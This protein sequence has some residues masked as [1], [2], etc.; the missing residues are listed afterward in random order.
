MLVVQDAW[1]AKLRVA[2]VGIAGRTVARGPDGSLSVDIPEGQHAFALLES[3]DGRLRSSVVDCGVAGSDKVELRVAPWLVR[4]VSLLLPRE[5]T[6]AHSWVAL[7]AG[8][9][10]GD[11]GRLSSGRC[12]EQDGKWTAEVRLLAQ[13]PTWVCLTVDAGDLWLELP[14][15]P[16]EV[17]I[18]P[19][20][21]PPLATLLVRD[22]AGKPVARALVECVMAPS[23]SNAAGGTPMPFTLGRTDPL[24]RLCLPS[25]LVGARAANVFAPGFAP[26][27]GSLTLAIELQPLPVRRVPLPAFE[28]TSTFF[29]RLF[30]DQLRAR[31]PAR[32]GRHRQ[33]DP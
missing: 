27:S 33:R 32:N 3:V 8:C 26:W 31:L 29:L 24:G 14:S 12:R 4:E 23:A 21:L 30:P 20:V 9:D 13:F 19:L 1:A 7:D 17:R 16:S 15:L 6:A 18:L 22:P 25:T 10:V 2:G 5:V 28:G 11:L